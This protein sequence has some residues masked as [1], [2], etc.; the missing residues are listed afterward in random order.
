MG[1][2]SKGNLGL[3]PDWLQKEEQFLTITGTEN[4]P[5]NIFVILEG[6]GGERAQFVPKGLQN[7]EFSR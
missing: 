3:V 4:T 6:Q 1:I 2:G 7:T 5:I